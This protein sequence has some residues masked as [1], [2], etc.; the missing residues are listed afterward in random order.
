MLFRLL[1][2]FAAVCRLSPR[3]GEWGLLSSC[4]GFSLQWLFLLWSI[5]APDH[6]LQW[7]WCAEHVESSQSRDWAQAP[8]IGRW[9]PTTGPPRKSLIDL[10]VWKNFRFTEKSQR[11]RRQFPLPV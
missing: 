7:L 3:C 6:R 4:S 9:I 10:L 1:W 8:C 11:Y 2:V 5:W